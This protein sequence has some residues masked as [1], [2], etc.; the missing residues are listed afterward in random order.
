MAKW[1]T[2]AFLRTFIGAG[3]IF[4]I[5]EAACWIHPPLVAWGLGAMDRDQI[6]PTYQILAGAQQHARIYDSSQEIRKQ[7]RFL[8]SDGKLNLWETSTGNWWVP[9]GSDG[10]TLGFAIQQREGIYGSGEWGIAAGDIVLDCGANVGT[11]TRHALDA[12][13]KIVVAIEPAPVN[14]ECLRRNFPKEIAAGRVIIA[15]VGVWDK[16]DVLPLYED[17]QNSG[18]DS[19][20][21]KGPNDHVTKVRLLAID[22]LVKEL[23]LGRVDVIKMDIKGATVRALQGG[24]QTIAANRPR[25]AIST[26]ELEDPP[27]AIKA[28]VISHMPS[29]KMACGVCSVNG[30]KVNADV[31]LFR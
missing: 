20:V 12:G 5:F 10:P 26:E 18:A 4:L 17:P 29:Y 19:F 1:V 8:R 13:A 31:L 25:L 16:E 30:L 3:C 2:F 11:Y 28:A 15:P 14:V 24:S 7:A 21:I 9:S 27:A 23:K 6:C 22:H